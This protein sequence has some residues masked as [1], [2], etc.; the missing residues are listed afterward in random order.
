MHAREPWVAR[1]Y[2]TM[3]ERSLGKERVRV[4]AEAFRP[5]PGGGFR[6][7][8]IDEL[9]PQLAVAL[10][11]QR[12]REH[13]YPIVMKRFDRASIEPDHSVDRDTDLNSCAVTLR[14]LG[15]VAHGHP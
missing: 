13:N 1:H 5:K 7:A 15:E 3:L 11:Y 14:P 10:G 12:G 6:P 9:A 8:T 4:I 2:V